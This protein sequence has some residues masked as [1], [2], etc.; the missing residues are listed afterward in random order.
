MW[1]IDLFY[2][3]IFMIPIYNALVKI[4]HK[5]L[6]EDVGYWSPHCLHLYYRISVDGIGC[7]PHNYNT[8]LIIMFSVCYYS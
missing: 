1:V 3:I 4:L 5:V 8:I 6:S 2:T 7:Y